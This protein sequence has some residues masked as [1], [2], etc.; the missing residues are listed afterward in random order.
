MSLLWIIRAINL[1][2]VLPREPAFGLQIFPL[3]SSR[4]SYSL[5]LYFKTQS[6]DAKLNTRTSRL[7]DPLRSAHRSHI[8]F[9]GRIR[10][11]ACF[12][13]PNILTTPLCVLDIPQRAY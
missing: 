1:L 3:S 2:I 10:Q 4:Y 7:S 9:Y 6:T 8:T 11:C 12:D 13:I 5:I